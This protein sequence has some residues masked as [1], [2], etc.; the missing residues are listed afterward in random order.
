[1]KSFSVRL[2]L[3]LAA[4]FLL[5]TL[6][7]LIVTASVWMGYFPGEFNARENAT[8]LS[9][10]SIKADERSRQYIGYGLLSIFVGVLFIFAF[11]KWF[12]RI[13]RETAQAQTWAATLSAHEQLVQLLKNSEREL[14]ERLALCTADLAS[15]QSALKE[16]VLAVESSEQ[17]AELSR[18][19]AIQTKD[20]L[21]SAQVLL[22]Q[23]EKMA[24]L[25]QLMAGVA[26]EINTP[27]TAVKA[28]GENI[29]DALSQ[30]LSS[31]PRLFSKLDAQ[32]RQ[33]FEALVAQAFSR[34]TVQSTREERNVTRD[35]AAF[36]AE[37]HVDDAPYKAGILVQLN[38]Q[39]RLA[40]FLP[41]LRH[42][43][44]DLIL[45]TAHSLANLVINARNINTAVDRV[46]KIILALKS[47]AHSSTGEWVDVDLHN[48]IEIVLTIFHRQIPQGVELACNFE[49]IAPLRCLPDELC[50]VWTNLIHNALQA[51]VNGGTLTIGLRRIANQAVVS[52]A[53]TGS[54]IPESIRSKIFDV[55]FT[56]K[57]VGVGSGLG[58]D[59]VKKII[60]K[61][62]GRIE[63]QSE[64]GVGT[65]FTVYLPYASV[66]GQR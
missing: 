61:H 10:F 46:S 23:F 47:F 58:L 42:V 36:L 17:R 55:F 26:H 54:G 48:N 22:I 57:P 24:S 18:C 20:A 40:E 59:I 15:S 19:E 30:A 37:N 39:S 52:I 45:D 12:N 49:D 66:E 32:S 4:W 14:E 25:G 38:A 1:M 60:D 43:E 34:T 44:T 7:V 2:N 29:A 62:H 35:V 13:R 27:I 16:S 6:L 64:V 50:Q 8:L 3:R 33:L 51:M 28:S 9:D 21:M 56:T 53:D 63:V 41:L 5:I 65:T 31:M 11:V